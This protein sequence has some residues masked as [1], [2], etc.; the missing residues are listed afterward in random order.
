MYTLDENLSLEELHDSI[1]EETKSYI[2]RVDLKV[3][4]EDASTV[5]ATLEGEVHIS[6][7]GENFSGAK[8][9]VYG[10]GSDMQEA[11]DAVMTPFYETTNDS[12]F[13]KKLAE[14]WNNGDH[15]KYTEEEDV[16]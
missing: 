4:V 13:I 5:K 3:D 10:Y 1:L 2:M 15:K 14:M 8:L 7:D 6:N 9:G 12:E 11:V 16:E